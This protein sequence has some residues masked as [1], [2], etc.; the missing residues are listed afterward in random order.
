MRVIFC[1][2][3]ECRGK[4]QIRMEGT[5][6]ACGKTNIIWI[7][8]EHLIT[9]SV[10]GCEFC[11]SKDTD[12]VKGSSSGKGVK[13]TADCWSGPKVGANYMELKTEKDLV[14]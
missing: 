5:C 14:I 13:W 7:T 6:R 12:K 1:P 2:A 11:G 4:P 10:I 3:Q 8:T 9:L